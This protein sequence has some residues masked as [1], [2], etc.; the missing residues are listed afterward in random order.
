MLSP[1]TLR[2]TAVFRKTILLVHLQLELKALYK[3][4]MQNDLFLNL[5]YRTMKKNMFIK[6]LC[7]SIFLALSSLTDAKAQSFEPVVGTNY[8]YLTRSTWKLSNIDLMDTISIAVTEDETFMYSF[9]V[10]LPLG[11]SNYMVTIQHDTVSTPIQYTISAAQDQIVLYPGTSYAQT[12]TIEYINDDIFI[13]RASY[14]VN[15]TTY[16]YRFKMVKTN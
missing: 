13:Y 1:L 2:Q 5:T 14:P 9:S 3:Y 12:F 8:Y 16:N 4:A 15:G 6:L 11:T 7:F 10:G